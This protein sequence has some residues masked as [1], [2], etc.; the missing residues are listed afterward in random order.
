[1][2][3]EA[4]GTGARRRR[5][6]AR[7]RRE[8]LLTAARDEFSR[9]GFYLTQ[10]EHV[11]AAAGVSKALVYQHFPSKEEL[12]AAVTEEVLNA[13]LARVPAVVATSGDALAVWRGAVGLLVGLVEENPEAWA[14]VARHLGDPDLS[15]S[16]HQLRGLL[17]DTF[18]TLLADF[19][20]P[21]P[22]GHVANRDEVVRVATLTVQQLIGALQGLLFWWLDHPDTPRAE[23]ERAALEFGWLGLDRLRRGERLGP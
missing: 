19:Y 20:E 10:M 18:A 9:R 13:F 11:A 7:A 15:G 21:E 17:T 3:Q 22:G 12:F 16:L 6:S 23:I 2:S 8:E 5:M 1:M 14:L 4:E